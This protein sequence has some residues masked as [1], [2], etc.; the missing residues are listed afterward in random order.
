MMG[1]ERERKKDANGRERSE[2][3]YKLCRAS[4]AVVEYGHGSMGV[5]F[6]LSS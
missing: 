6:I 1:V 4:G 3:V 5:L 2:K